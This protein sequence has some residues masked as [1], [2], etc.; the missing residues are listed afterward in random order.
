MQRDLADRARRGDHDAFA[1]LVDGS[2]GRLYAVARLIVRD[3]D[4]AYDAVQ[5]AL[6]AAWRDIRGLRDPDRVDA[7]LRRL[8]VRACYRQAQAERRRSVVELRVVPEDTTGA[9]APELSVADRD[10]LERAFA[11]LAPEHRAVLV[12]RYYL[13]LS[14]PEVADSLDI[15][16]GTA[17]SRLNRAIAEMRAAL[18][19][20]DRGGE[21]ARGALG[22][23]NVFDTERLLAAW[24]EAE[25]PPRAPDGLRDDILTATSRI[26]PRP[27]WLAQLKGNLMDLIVGGRSGRSQ[28]QRLVPLLVS[29]ALLLALAVGA[30]IVGSQLL[31]Q[32]TPVA[33]ISRV[34]FTEPLFQVIFGDDGTTWA[35]T[36]RDEPGDYRITGIHRID[37]EAGT[38]TP[39]VTDLPAGH[40][41]F[42]VV[43]DVIWATN[44]ESGTWRSWDATTGAKLGDGEIGARPLEPIAAFGYVWQPLFEG[45]EVVR[46]HPGTGDMVRIPFA[47]AA[48][49]LVPDAERVWVFT[50]DGV[51]SAVDPESATVTA[52][53]RPSYLT[54]G[55]SVAGGRV[56]AFGCDAIGRAEVFE[57]DGTRA[58]MYVSPDA[59]PWFAFDYDGDVWVVESTQEVRVFENDTFRTQ[60]SVT[61]VVRL[62]PATL[63]PLATFDLG[64]GVG[65]SGRS[66]VVT[67]SLDSDALWL[68]QGTDVIRVPLAA[69]PERPGE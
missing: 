54:C 25:A 56:W 41:S 20:D 3:P 69:L 19:A 64:E 23:T 28:T 33:P 52:E 6:V 53:L 39:V 27:A 34:P 18:E 37:R 31:K 38:A 36:V 40:T 46:V 32:P 24:L 55:G 29:L 42:V 66:D 61:R 7:W 68:V 51:V 60:P 26:R 48:R 30:A 11:R 17:K 22:M 21:L 13:D 12:L 45:W 15:P 44:D 1:M 10:L 47:D 9:V 4:R 59:I 58:G 62:D 14:V 35:S 49:A 43:D 65:L 67:G 2:L 8:V 57:P 5:E 63:K 16:L 50:L